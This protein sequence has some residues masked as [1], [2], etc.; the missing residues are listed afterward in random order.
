MILE[1]KQIV[2]KPESKCPIPCPN[3][4]QILTLSLN[5]TKYFRL[6]LKD[7]QAERESLKRHETNMRQT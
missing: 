5:K 4:P 6:R 7:D 3:R 2:V 1:T